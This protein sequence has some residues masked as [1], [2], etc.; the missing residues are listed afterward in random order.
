VYLH[1]AL[2][3]RRLMT[4]R[5]T[6]IKPAVTLLAVGSPKPEREDVSNHKK[7]GTKGERT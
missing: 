4:S 1:L 7:R 3:G 6:E 2:V 5:N